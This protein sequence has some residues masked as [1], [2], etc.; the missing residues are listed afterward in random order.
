MKDDRIKA[1]KQWPEPKSVRNIQVFLGF[2]N[3]HRQ[4]IQEF[5]RIVA[6][7]SSMLKTKGSTWSAANLKKTKGEIGG[8][9]MDDNMVGGDETTNPT[10]GKNQAKMTKSKILVKF[11]NHDFSKSKTEKAKRDFFTPKARLAFTQLKQ[12]F[13]EAPIFYYFDPESHIR[14]ETDRSS[15]TIGN[16]LSQLSSST[17]LN[18]VV[19]KANLGQWHLVAFFLREMIPIETR[20]KIHDG[21]LLAIVKALKT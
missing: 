11:K 16:I 19:T 5:S 13:V 9:S 20:Y 17:R 14:I 6:P 18:E 15:Y 4:F 8:D 21:E 3:F 12:A 1:V 2:A 7:L 10:R